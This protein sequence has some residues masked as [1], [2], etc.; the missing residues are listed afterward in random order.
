MIA[1][2]SY[3]TFTIMLNYSTLWYDYSTV[4]LTLSTKNHN[5]SALSS[6]NVLRKCFKFFYHFSNMQFTIYI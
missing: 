6:E 5:S 3:A 2:D 1:S 4:S